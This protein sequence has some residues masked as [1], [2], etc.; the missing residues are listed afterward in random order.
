MPFVGIDLGTTNSAM[1]FADPDQGIGVTL[2]PVPQLVGEGEVAPR[3]TLPSVVYLAGDDDVAP[4]AL[5]LPWREDDRTAVGLLGRRLG[6]R[7]AGR[8][9]TS[10]K[11]WLCHG[12]VDREAAILPWGSPDGAR[13]LSPVAASARV[14]AHLREAWDAAHPGH[15]L[16]RQEV[17]LT[18]PASF[19]AVAR[20]LTVE[21]AAAAGLPEVRLLEEPQAAL[22]AWLDANPSWR[23]TLEGVDSVLVVD[24]GGG[25]TDFSL[26]AVERGRNGLALERVA[27]G[28]H[29]LLGGDNVDVA[30]ARLVESRDGRAAPLDAARWAQLTALCREAKERLLGDEPPSSVTVTLPGR[31]RG[32]VAGTFAAELRREEVEELVLDGFFQAVAA[33]A[34]P[35]ADAGPGL[36]EFGLPFASDP[37]VTR[38]LAEFLSRSSAAP[39]AVLFNGG[40][41]AP[42]VVRERL[43][44][45]LASWL[46]KRP[47]EL[48]GTDLDLAVA[49]GAATYALARAGIGTRVAGG[50][51]RVYYVEV[52][53]G[54]A[55]QLLCVAPRGMAE[56]DATDLPA[57]AFEVVAN[58]PARFPIH[59][60]SV[61]GDEA[62]AL[63]AVDAPGLAAVGS[64]ETVLRF[65]RSL[66][67]RSIPVSLEARLTE[68]GTLEIWCRSRSTEHRWKLDFDLRARK[69][70]ASAAPGGPGD[71]LIVPQERLEAAYALLAECFGTAR[72]PAPDGAPVDPAD[73]PKRLADT[74]LSGKDSWPLGAVRSLFDRLFDL[75]S[76]RGK[77]AAHE[78]RWLNLAGFCV[79]PGFGEARDGWRVERLW[80]LFAGGLRFPSSPQGRAEWWTLWKR[81][82]G[83][84]SRQQQ[85]ALFNQLKAFLLP[86]PQRSRPTGARKPQA[87][88]QEL[89]EMWMAAGSLDKI[90][91]EARRDLAAALA[92][93]VSKG[94][95]SDAE[96]WAFGRLCARSPLAGPANTV[97]SPSVV[98]P[99]LETLV[100]KPWERPAAVALALAQAARA[101]GDRH[102]DL[103]DDLRER[104]A[105]RLESEPEGKRLAPLVRTV[106][107]F[108]EA[109]RARLL[110][111]VLPVGLR[112]AAPDT[113]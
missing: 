93:R 62:G 36:A 41:L 86:Q 22:Y 32:V 98:A 87:L 1:A 106:A 111:E 28:D 35:R 47:V 9:V 23:R 48:P 69:A 17:V 10:S 71:V 104:V 59:A 8:L 107:E 81:A 101:T 72:T 100:V 92:P 83:G 19:D 82:A 113:P 15:P 16:G 77:S 27:V 29:L 40:A 73:L 79:R 2:F 109:D 63:V 70:V 50:A 52:H 91:A 34:R 37:A 99:W 42:P 66:A 103:P 31:G 108:A 44:R 43:M 75:A 74:F 97:I 11:S 26:V 95:G 3:A 105:A 5:A 14:L 21:A 76:G 53:A 88:A 30:L 58:T 46:G 64:V 45:V 96:T 7:I 84:L 89:R 68:V 38:H 18:V 51:A 13:K 102:R 90:A 61:R 56:G 55:T 78:T 25:T 60:S 54:E 80:R 67:E 4:G 85:Q 57:L 12:G 49:K 65:G 39:G 112:L 110:A 6:E 24:V 94:K 20:E 33:S